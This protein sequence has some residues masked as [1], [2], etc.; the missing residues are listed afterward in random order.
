MA[1]A[2]FRARFT[3]PGQDYDEIHAGYVLYD[4]NGKFRPLV[5]TS[6]VFNADFLGRTVRE[7]GESPAGR[8][9]R[10]QSPSMLFLFADGQTD[11]TLPDEGHYGVH[12]P[13]PEATLDDAFRFGSNVMFDPF[14]H[15]R[16]V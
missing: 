2:T 6:Y 1:E 12:D 14:R 13:R 9:D 15:R 7:Y 5:R 11:S 8:V 4:W 10:V 3:C 16:R